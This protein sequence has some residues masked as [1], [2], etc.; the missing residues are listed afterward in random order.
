MTEEEPIEETEEIEVEFTSRAEY[1]ASCYNA[2]AAAD[3]VDAIT[4]ED[5]RR[6]KRIFRKSLR[7]IDSLITEM[8]D[9][10]FED[11]E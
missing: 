8:H 3:S 1:I 7:I 11:E 6:K 10:L 4:Q 2:I 9:E 5:Q